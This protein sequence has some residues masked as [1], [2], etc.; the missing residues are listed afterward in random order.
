MFSICIWSKV[1]CMAHQKH[2][3]YST[4]I[5]VL[6]VGLARSAFAGPAAA[7]DA[8]FNSYVAG[9]ESRLAQQHRVAS[10]FLAPEDL[11]RLRKGEPIIEKLS[12]SSPPGFPGAMLHHW[13]GTAFAPGATASDFERL[14]RNFAAYPKHYAPQ[15]VQARVLAQQGDHYQVL[16]RVKQHH[17]ITVVMDTQYD[18]TFSQFDAQHGSSLSHSTRIS[19]I[20]SPGTANE[21]ALSADEDHGLLWRL[22][23]YWSYEERDGGVYMQI[24]SVSLTRSI[25]AGLGWAVGPFVESVPRD[26]LEF[27][28]SSTCNALKG[29]Q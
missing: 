20:S 1:H 10:T 7:A 22:N 27:T 18:V 13:R 4:L 23:T 15:V 17:V 11:A 24:E 21:R 6:L 19:E 9:V 29:R 14:M 12:P 25:P 3:A 26:S 28:L 16:M 5:A 2:Q 8:S